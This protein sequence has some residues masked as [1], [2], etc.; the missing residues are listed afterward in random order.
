MTKLK[1]SKKLTTNDLIDLKA[2]LENFAERRLIG[3]D[4]FSLR[5]G[6]LWT[7]KQTI[8]PDG[9]INRKEQ[10]IFMYFEQF[11]QLN[12]C[13]PHFNIFQIMDV[14]E[15]NHCE[16]ICRIMKEEVA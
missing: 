9:S 10:T 3:Y 2:S 4:T 12:L 6:T 5:N 15:D 13:D 11:N 7:Y 14:L 1:I 8:H 16:E